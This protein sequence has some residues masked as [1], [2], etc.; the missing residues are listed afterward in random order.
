M[1]KAF[2]LFVLLTL[3][4]AAHAQKVTSG[5]LQ[6]TWAV[7]SITDGDVIIYP[8][9]GRGVLTE[10]AK[11]GLTP[12][13][14]A[15]EEEY[16]AYDVE[17]FKDATITFSGNAIHGVSGGEEDMDGTFTLNEAGTGITI[18]DNGEEM[19]CTISIKEGKLYIVYADEGTEAVLRKVK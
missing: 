8:E 2:V 17:S 15:E 16:L 14:I 5:I 1:K 19:V 4:V 3:S 6:G 10:S 7:V 11:E 9:E 13:E 18:L 12:A